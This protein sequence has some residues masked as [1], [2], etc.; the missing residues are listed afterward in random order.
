MAS[1]KLVLTR[2]RYFATFIIV[3]ML[4]GNLQMVRDLLVRFTGLVTE[5]SRISPREAVTWQMVLKE[6][7]H[8]LQVY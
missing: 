5:Y 3:S 8:F 6:V 1:A 7:T 2:L 4:D